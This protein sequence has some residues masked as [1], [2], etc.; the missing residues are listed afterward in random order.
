ME[1]LNRLRTDLKNIF[2]SSS[3][4]TNIIYSNQITNDYKYL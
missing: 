2:E 1:D 4:H 3:L